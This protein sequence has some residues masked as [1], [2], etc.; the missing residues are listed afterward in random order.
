MFDAWSFCLSK[1]F[2]SVLSTVGGC[3]SQY[4]I[5]VHAYRKPT[6]LVTTQMVL[7]VMNIKKFRA[8][9]RPR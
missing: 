2:T 3:Y 1:Q 4:N 7:N 5:V 8:I 9:G 6:N